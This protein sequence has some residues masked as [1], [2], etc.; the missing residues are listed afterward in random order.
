MH[1][2]L[3]TQLSSRLKPL[4][5]FSH[6]SREQFEFKE[7]KWSN[8]VAT[9]TGFSG[10]TSFRVFLDFGALAFDNPSVGVRPTCSIC[11]AG[12]FCPHAL[13]MADLMSNCGITEK[14]EENE[15]GPCTFSFEKRAGKKQP[16]PWIAQLG[17]LAQQLSY[18]ETSEPA[19]A[20]FPTGREIIYVIQHERYS[21]LQGMLQINIATRPIGLSQ[22][23][24]PATTRVSSKFYRNFTPGVRA[25][26]LSAD[27]LDREIA[28]KISLKSRSEDY[29]QSRQEL[30][31]LI[32]LETSAELFARLARS[33]RL[34]LNTEYHLHDG[35]LPLTWLCDENFDLKFQI[36]ARKPDQLALN[37]CAVNSRMTVAQHDIK[38]AAA[39]FFVDEQHRIGLFREQVRAELFTIIND[40]KPILVPRAQANALIEKVMSI[41]GGPG[42]E[43][44]GCDDIRPRHIVCTP[45]PHIHIKAP[46]SMSNTLE[47][48]VQ[49][50]YDGAAVPLARRMNAFYDKRRVAIVQIDGEFHDRSLALLTSLG[51]KMRQSYGEPSL[52]LPKKKLPAIVGQLIRHG[53]H[54]EADGKLIAPVQSVISTSSAAS[55][56]LNCRARPISIRPASTCPGLIQCL[57]AGERSIVLDDGTIGVIPE[58]WIKRFGGLAELATAED[59]SVKFGRSQVGLLDA[60]SPSRARSTS[61]KI[62]RGSAIPAGV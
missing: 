20:R 24:E 56:G 12:R 52:T 30:Q 7:I 19:P 27:P 34:F 23:P 6:R 14:I 5:T 13:A 59:G 25:L 61:T 3:S 22:S 58:E 32:P 60:C 35:I 18:S 2:K 37:V 4:A 47:A 50:D 17:S 57:R 15:Y 51:V 10:P 29:Y 11:G 55:T 46:P 41:P 31:F 49:F 33:G 21:R 8:F 36:S 1:A 9:A 39:R 28:E 48:K 38:V 16:A 42:I 53:W 40:T 54:V 26:A 45:R 44:A 43:F 62:R